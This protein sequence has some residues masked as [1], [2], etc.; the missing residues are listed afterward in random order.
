MLIDGRTLNEGEVIKTD[1]CILGGGPAGI[2]LANELNG[3]NLKVVLLDAGGEQYE[4]NIQQFYEADSVPNFYPDPQISRLRFLGGAS[5]HWANNTSPFSPLD[6]EKRD[7]IANSGWPIGYD[8]LAPYYIK[9][10]EYCQT[11][12]DGYSSEYW[13]PLMELDD[14]MQEAM[15][16]QL[17]IAKASLP[18]TRFYVSHGKSLVESANVYIYKY[19]SVIDLEFDE[20]EKRVVSATFTAYNGKQY[21]VLSDRFVLSMGGLENARMLLLFNEKYNGRLG[22]ESD[23]VG[24]YFMDHPTMNAAHLFSEVTRLDSMSRLEGQRFLV[25]FFELT[26]KALREEKLI[27]LRMPV[28]SVTEYGMSDGISSFHILKNSLIKGE[29]PDYFFT[30]YGNLILDADMVIEA[31]AR[32]QFDTKVFDSAKN[33]PGYQIPMMVEQIP[34]RNN[35]IHL[36]AKKDQFDLNKLSIEWNVSEQNRELMWRA[37]E[38]F[39]RDMGITSIGRLRLLRERASR[40]FGDQMGFG[41]HHMGTTRMSD[42]PENGVVDENCKVFGVGN[43]YIAGSS[44]FPTG[45]H[46]PP[47]LTI[48]ALSVRLADHLKGIREEYHEQ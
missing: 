40:L 13:L 48:T 8:D 9:A 12:G 18:P 35:R 28:T 26:E 29:L 36:S 19:A 38:V 21:K 44:V 32:K 4:A 10:A 33:K 24:R 22:N 15:Y 5:N 46:V 34:E 6:F 2:T 45:S 41:H 20:S 1:I 42:T 23:N 14:L 17:S 7:W 37:L 16:S 47:T 30:H 31:I 11:G 25:A 43:L 3:S 27:N 39:A